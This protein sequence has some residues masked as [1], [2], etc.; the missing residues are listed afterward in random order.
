MPEPPQGVNKK[1]S[2]LKKISLSRRDLLSQKGA[3]CF[4]LNEKGQ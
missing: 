2:V 4:P 1:Q 3:F